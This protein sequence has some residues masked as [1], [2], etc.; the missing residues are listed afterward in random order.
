[1]KLVPHHRDEL[2]VPGVEVDLVGPA[3][4]QRAIRTIRARLGDQDILEAIA[5]HID[6]LRVLAR[7]G[8]RDIA[9]V[10]RGVGDVGELE[11]PVVAQKLEH[12]S[13][14]AVLVPEH[15][16]DNEI[17]IAVIVEIERVYGD[18]VRGVAGH[19]GRHVVVFGIAF[20]IG[21]G[22][23]HRIAPDRSTVILNV[24]KNPA[25]AQRWVANVG[26][27]Q[28]NRDDLC[29][30]VPVEVGGRHVAAEAP[31]YAPRG[32]RRHISQAHVVVERQRLETAFA[33]AQKCDDSLV[34]VEYLVAARGIQP[35][36]EGLGHRIARAQKIELPVA[37]QITDLTIVKCAF[38]TRVNRAQ[39]AVA[40]VQ[41]KRRLGVEERAFVV[42]V[43]EQVQLAVVV[44]ITHAQRLRPWR[45]RPA[46]HF[47]GIEKLASAR[48]GRD[49]HERHIRRHARSVEAA[50]GPAAD[51]HFGPSVAG[52]IARNAHED[53]RI[54]RS[55]KH[56]SRNFYSK[57]T[58]IPLHAGRQGI[59]RKLRT[60]RHDP[61][62][63]QAILTDRH[64]PSGLSRHEQTQLRRPPPLAHPPAHL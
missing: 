45:A 57:R 41:V 47:R 59:E 30:A 2:A 8:P 31:V 25:V 60:K 15:R 26:N 19:G 33:I 40:V 63:P 22:Q 3:L 7:I 34:V 44:E 49:E 17:E 42:T 1:M 23:R 35:G 28:I 11:F 27:Q 10:D 16:A 24:G 5:V 43:H 46:Q 4:V 52:Q 64:K 20:E 13:A 38:W 48:P 21:L 36:I 9:V 39:R 53:R 12:G 29:L 62:F 51:H 55:M 61:A 6:E 54:I 37:V 58:L 56:R 32:A 18:V 14:V 50:I